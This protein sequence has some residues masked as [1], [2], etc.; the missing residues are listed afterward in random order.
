M[1][2][3]VRLVATFAS[4]SICSTV[5]AQTPPIRKWLDTE[6][7][8]TNAA[9]QVVV[10]QNSLPKGGGGY[11][12]AADK[13][14]S[15]VIFWT[16]I[17]NKSAT[18]LRVTM[19]CPADPIT[20]FPSPTSHIRILLP[21]DTMTLDKVALGDYGLTSLQSFVDERFKKPSTLEKTINPQ[22]DHLF[23]MTVLMHQA[24]GTAR[25]ALTLRNDD[26]SLQIRIG[27][28]STVIPCG[29]LAFQN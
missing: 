19:N 18:P 23:Y 13:Q 1:T 24:R 17:T 14:Y 22:E 9:G 29:R 16:R 4:L 28:D 20:M 11:V 26:L 8:Y 6:V 5:L 7:A 12:H 15:Y 21:P 25:A 27:T 2:V 10:I 3:V